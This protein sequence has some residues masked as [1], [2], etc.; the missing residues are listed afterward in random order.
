MLPLQVSDVP[1]GALEPAADDGVYQNQGE[2]VCDASGADSVSAAR[3]MPAR[4]HG[5]ADQPWC[6]AVQASAVCV[7][8]LGL[9][10]SADGPVHGPIS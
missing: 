9:L 7:C 1:G 6:K 3:V 4:L 8:Q 5:R 2:P 10:S